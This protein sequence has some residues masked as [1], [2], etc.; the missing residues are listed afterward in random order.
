MPLR[1]ETNGTDSMPRSA[2]PRVERLRLAQ[3]AGVE[4]AAEAAVAGQDQHGRPGR[5]RRLG[6]QRVVDVGRPADHRLDRGR[7]LTRVRLGGPSSLLRLDDPRRRDELLSL[8]DLGGGLDR[9]IR[10]LTARSCAPIGYLLPPPG[11]HDAWPRPRA[12]SP[13][14]PPLGRLVGDEQ[15][16]RRWSRTRAGTRRS[17]PCSAV[18]VSSDSSPVSL[19]AS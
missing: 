6:G 5:I 15:L 10:R 2:Q 18:T 1:P 19:I 4:A 8:G 14:P 16:A 9:A 13:L 7:D 3:H 17:R 12:R 11:G